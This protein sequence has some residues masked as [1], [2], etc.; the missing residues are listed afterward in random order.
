M[1]A[2]SK[3]IRWLK[4]TMVS[5]RYP[6]AGHRRGGRHSQGCSQDHPPTRIHR[7]GDT[8]RSTTG[9]RRLPG[10]ARIPKWNGGGVLSLDGFH[11]EGLPR[12]RPA[13]PTLTLTQPGLITTPTRTA[14]VTP[15]TNGTPT[16]TSTPAPAYAFVSGGFE[17]GV[18]AGA[19]TAETSLS[20][21]RKWL[22]V[23]SGPF[24]PH[25]FDLS[26]HYQFAG[27]VMTDACVKPSYLTGMRR[28][29][30]QRRSHC[31]Q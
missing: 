3:L 1:D 16:P 15:T 31:D 22:A 27:F 10:E 14:T 26:Q 20:Q 17:D 2:R 8:A 7:F 5:L 4:P 19:S 29:Q 25:W 12:S 28:P 6:V 13:L 9:H 30:R 23:R 11:L 24:R 18:K 21:N